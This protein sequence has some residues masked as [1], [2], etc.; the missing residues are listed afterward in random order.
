MNFPYDNSMS[1]YRST[2]VVQSNRISIRI[3]I[4]IEQKLASNQT[5]SIE[6]NEKLVS[7]FTNNS[8]FLL[9]IYIVRNI[10]VFLINF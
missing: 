9:F 7:E 1:L 10:I 8:I 6:R 5:V 3:Y 2:I 4:Q